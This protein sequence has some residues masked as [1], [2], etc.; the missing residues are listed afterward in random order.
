MLKKTGDLNFPKLIT[1]AQL[2]TD[3]NE[4]ISIY[5]AY[6]PSRICTIWNFVLLN[7]PG[8]LLFELPHL[9]IDNCLNLKSLG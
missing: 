4:G 2:L 3:Y 6:Q 5:I 8:L 9:T 1:T 7:F